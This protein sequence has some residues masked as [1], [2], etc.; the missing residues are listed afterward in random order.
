MSLF[1]PQSRKC[2]SRF[3]LFGINLNKLNSFKICQHGMCAFIH[4]II[5]LIFTSIP[6][7][8]WFCRRKERDSEPH[9]SNLLI[10]DGCNGPLKLN[11]MSLVLDESRQNISQ[12][13][14]CITLLRVQNGEVKSEFMY[15]LQRKVLKLFFNNRHLALDAVKIYFDGRG[16]KEIQNRSWKNFSNNKESQVEVVITHQKEEVDDVIVRLV[17]RRTKHPPIIHSTSLEDLKFHSKFS[18][19]NSSIL[20]LLRNHEGAGKSRRVLK[21]FC[22]VR[23][24]SIYSLFFMTPELRR[25]SLNDLRQ[26]I[27]KNSNVFQK[28]AQSRVLSKND[29]TIVVTDDVYLRQRILEAGGV[30]LTFEQLWSLLS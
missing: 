3:S 30:V 18:D 12:R 23:P 10:I 28:Y 13:K 22:L 24:A 27:D 9:G 26:L 16:M 7:Y 20:T 29:E 5:V 1:R 6:V 21:P 2:E 19:E 4:A 25:Q 15:L 14:R 11:K 8:I 17:Q